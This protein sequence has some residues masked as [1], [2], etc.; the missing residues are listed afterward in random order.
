ML[1]YEPHRTE[2]HS[3]ALIPNFDDRGLLQLRLP[4]Q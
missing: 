2:V 1:P 4:L 3:K